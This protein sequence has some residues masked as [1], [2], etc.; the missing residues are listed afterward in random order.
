MSIEEFLQ[1]LDFFSRPYI[2]VFRQGCNFDM[3]ALKVLRIQSYPTLEGIRYSE[4]NDSNFCAWYKLKLKK[5]A[6]VCK[7]LKMLI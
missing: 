5:K 2:L 4:M 3:Q 6:Y 7:Y 1:N